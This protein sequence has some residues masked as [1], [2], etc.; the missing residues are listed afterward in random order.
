MGDSILRLPH[1]AHGK[2]VRN[3]GPVFWGVASSASDHVELKSHKIILHW[4]N[5]SPLTQLTMTSFR[6]DRQPH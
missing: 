3:S 5:L 4:T 1:R 2:V 6:D